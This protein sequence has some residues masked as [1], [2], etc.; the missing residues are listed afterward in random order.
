MVTL[1]ILINRIPSDVLNR[2]NA[3]LPNPDKLDKYVRK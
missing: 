2:K 3:A 1:L